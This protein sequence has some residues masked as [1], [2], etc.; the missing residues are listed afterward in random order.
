MLQPAPYNT[1]TYRI[2]ALAP[3]LV[4]LAAA[5][6]GVAVRLIEVWRDGAPGGL[7][8]GLSPF[9]LLVVV[10]ALVHCG[11]PPAP[12]AVEWRLG[13]R[14]A[15]VGALLL[16]PSS[17][18]AWL[19][20]AFYAAALAWTGRGDRRVGALLFLGLALAAL[21]SSVALKFLAVPVTTME[22]V[23]VKGLLAT[24]VPE[25]ERTGNTIGILGG[26]H[27]VLLTACTS[28]D[29]LPRLLL[30][31][32]ALSHFAGGAEA[33]RIG[34]ACVGA[35]IAFVAANTARLAVM[36]LSSQAYADAH[37]AL[38]SGLFDGLQVSIA[39]AAAWWAS[40]P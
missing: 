2:G 6:N 15:L 23:L 31:V 38:G 37:G 8:P 29:A 32:V 1:S 24:F 40:R 25:I 4:L 21:W 30:S 19:A 11:A 17:A 3:A 34:L 28:A 35:V 9:E 33:R 14:E 39:V 13:W 36:A 10:V 5:L 20:L 26:H 12:D 16:V 22:A 27:L 7:L 18:V